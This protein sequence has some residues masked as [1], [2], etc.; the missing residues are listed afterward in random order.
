MKRKFNFFIKLSILVVFTFTF[1]ACPAHTK[2]VRIKS[3]P[4][5][6]KEVMIVGQVTDHFTGGG[7]NLYEIDDTTGKIWVVTRNSLP[8]INTMVGVQGDVSTNFNVGGRDF[9]TVIQEKK[10]VVK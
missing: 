3:N 4:S 2:I 5:K 10:R 1:I 6:Y 9:G 7:T 8:S